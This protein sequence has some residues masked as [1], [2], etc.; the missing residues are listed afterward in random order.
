[1][2]IIKSVLINNKVNALML[3][4]YLNRDLNE[5]MRL[6]GFYYNAAIRSDI[7]RCGVDANFF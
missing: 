4:F 5:F 2:A 1:M 6:R 7:H 3:Q